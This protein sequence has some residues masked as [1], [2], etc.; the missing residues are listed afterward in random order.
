MMP[1]Y[2]IFRDETYVFYLEADSRE[3]AREMAD[4]QVCD[5]RELVSVHYEV[6]EEIPDE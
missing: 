3:A 2:K 4:D 1:K 5:E 6:I